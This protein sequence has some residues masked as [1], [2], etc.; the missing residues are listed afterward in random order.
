MKDKLN[1]KKEIIT[2]ICEILVDNDCILKGD[3]N[4]LISKISSGKIKDLEWRSIFENK[5]KTDNET[6]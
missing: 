4:P 1:T 2:N 3:L 6:K 5:L